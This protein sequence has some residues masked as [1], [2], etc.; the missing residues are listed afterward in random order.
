MR[1]LALY[2]VIPYGLTRRHQRRVEAQT[3]T[4]RRVQPQPSSVGTSTSSGSGQRR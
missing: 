4:W 3:S 2:W 1:P